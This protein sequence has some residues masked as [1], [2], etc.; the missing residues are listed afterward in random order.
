MHILFLACSLVI[1]S[2]IFQFENSY[3]IHDL[4]Q[5]YEKSAKDKATC[6]KLIKHL[7]NYK[8]QDPVVRGFGAGAQGMMAKYAWS[9]YYKIKYLHT[10]AQQ[11]EE[12]IKQHPQV[13]EVRFL[14]YSLEYFIPRYLNMSSHLDEDKK[15]FLD[16]LFRYPKSDID[17]EVY[18]IMRT[19]LQR[20][21]DQLTEQEKKQ[22]QNLKT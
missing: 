13:A 6:E 18:Q 17:G 19:F 14:R 21:P 11:F 12:I 9:P 20:H 16:S 15:V 22:I 7:N 1:T 10:S 8:G 4:R 2:F 5:F 3:K